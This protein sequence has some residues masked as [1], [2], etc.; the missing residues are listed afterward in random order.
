MIGIG[1]ASPRARALVEL[2][3]RVLLPVVPF[4]AA[5]LLLLFVNKK[6]PL[7]TWLLWPYAGLW[8]ATALWVASCT[9]VGHAALR[10]LPDLGLP[11]RERLLFDFATGVLLFALGLFLLGLL[12]LLRPPFFFLYPLALGATGAKSLTS[13]L[14]RARRH[15]RGVGRRAWRRHPTPYAAYAFGTLGL[16]I[17]YLTIMLPENAAFDSL[18]YHLP[19]AEHFAAGG[20]VG[21]FVEGWVAG[22]IPHLASWLYT[23]PFTLRSVN[24]FGHVELAAHIEFVLFVATVFSIPLLVEAICRRRARGTWAVIFLFPGLFLYDSSLSLAADHVLAFWAVPI[25]LALRRVLKRPA[26]PAPGVLAGLMIAGAVLT[27]YQA[28]SLVGPALL[29][30]AFATGREL[31]RAR[32]KTA[33]PPV[34]N[35]QLLRGLGA[36]ALTAVVATSAHWLANVVWYGD[37][38]YP[39]LRAWL[40]SHPMVKGWAGPVAAFSGGMTEWMPSGTFLEKV[41]QSAIGIFTFAFIPHDW[42]NFHRDLPVFGFLFTLTLPVLALARGAGRARLLAAGTL[43]GLFIWYWT[44]HQDRYLQALLPWMVAVTS[45]ALLLAW[46]GGVVARLG[47]VGLVAAQLVW[48]ND[49]PWLPNHAMIHD[50]PALRSLQRLSSTYRGEQGGRFHYDT[51]FEGLD[52]TLP[53]DATVLLHEEYLKLGLNRRALADSARLQP[54]IDYRELARPDRV[55]DLLKSLGVTHLVWSHGPSIDREVPVSGEL[56]F[57]GYALRYT[58]DRQ[59]VGAFGVAKLP[60]RRPPAREPGSVAIVAC[61]VVRSVRLADVDPLLAG[62][63]PA[64]PDVDASA[65]IAAAEFVV[66]EKACHA[67]ALPQAMSPFAQASDWGGFTLW[68]RRL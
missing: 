38:L 3:R 41:G 64:A 8:L 44:F 28:I 18:T 61:G 55:D 39:M 9:S 37:P 13:Y 45:A 47:V 22:V 66:V 48:G 35:R 46:E 65:A 5:A 1:P 50:V 40:P 4:A 67:K 19:I 32:K 56:V 26:A 30:A 34:S 31:W 60:E 62:Q 63:A 14:R 6:E 17:V 52:H 24:L 59:D 25:A 7:E 33:V 29:L 58:E 27:K 2:T 57:F 51:G 42:P 20:R 16:T 53:R 54:A 43:F 12:H 21:K 36:L 10:F 49:V 11:F 15:F 23:W 68:V